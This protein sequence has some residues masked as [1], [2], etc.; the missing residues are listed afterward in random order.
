MVDI[1]PDYMVYAAVLA[2]TYRTATLYT[3]PNLI[4]SYIKDKL[5]PKDNLETKLKKS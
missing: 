5:A 1:N 4:V 2:E 3:T